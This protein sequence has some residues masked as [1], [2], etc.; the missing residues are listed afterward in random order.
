MRLTHPGYAIVQR[1]YDRSVKY[2]HVCDSLQGL[3]QSFG[4][5]VNYR[6]NLDSVGEA[7][8]A[9][10]Q[11]SVVA[12][13]NVAWTFAKSQDKEEKSAA[14]RLLKGLE[15]S[16]E[17]A[18]LVGLYFYAQVFDEGQ[19]IFDSENT[20]DS[21][22]AFP[23]VYFI[24]RG[25]V[26]FR[27]KYRESSPDKSVALGGGEVFADVIKLYNFLSKA[28]GKEFQDLS[29]EHFEAFLGASTLRAS[30][31]SETHIFVLP[32]DS[33]L[34]TR[35]LENIPQSIAMIQENSIRELLKIQSRLLPDTSRE[36]RL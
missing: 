25:G 27:I 21:S 20:S 9:Y 23:A 31:T 17:N 29:L 1:L 6:Y 8:R 11:N 16:E 32:L 28:S 30:A 35:A 22:A 14:L 24:A 18:R 33:S 26:D 5:M 12:S 15:P 19:V 7:A 2:L 36:P 10:K 13:S 4:A 3:S 34:V